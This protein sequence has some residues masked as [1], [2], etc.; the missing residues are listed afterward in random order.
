MSA[1][2]ASLERVTFAQAPQIRLVE[3]LAEHGYAAG[4]E[5]EH[6]DP[7]G[8]FLNEFWYEASDSFSIADYRVGVIHGRFAPSIWA[9]ILGRRRRV[10]GCV[11]FHPAMLPN[12]T[13][14]CDWFVGIYGLDGP[15]VLFRRQLE[16]LA[17]AFQIRIAAEQVTTENVLEGYRW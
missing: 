9:R 16:E 10:V 1:G 8:N 17:S 11:H 2:P 6:R 3:W 4:R 5:H 14:N 12:K 13:G 7:R 15:A